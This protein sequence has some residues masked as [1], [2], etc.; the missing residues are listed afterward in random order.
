[1]K[2]KKN[3]SVKGQA[4]TNQIAEKNKTTP[5]WFYLILILIPFV[6]IISL[7]VFLRAINYGLDFEQFVAVSE[8]HPDKYYPNPDLPYKYFYNIKSAPSVLPDGFDII[9]KGNAFRVFV[10]G[11]SSAA[12]WPYVPNASFSRQLKRKLEL[13]YPENT[14]E[15]IN[16]G[17][18]AINSYTLRDFVPGILKQ[19]PDLILIYAG[20]NEYYGALGAGSSVSIG[21]S[22]FLVNTYL[23]LRDFKTV[24]LIQNTLSWIYGL[25]TG[26][27]TDEIDKQDGETLMS[28]MIGES[29]ITLNS[30]IFNAGISQ[31]E[32]NL[33]DILGW[34]KEAGIPVIIGNLTANLRDQK[35]LVSVK[36]DKLPAADEI[37]NSA[38]KTLAEG[39]IE[40]AKELFS[41]AKELDALR[42]R[43]PQKINNIIKKLAVK[44]GDSFINI[45]SVFKSH[46]PNGIVGNNLTVDHLHPNINGYWMMGNEYFKMMEKKNLLPKR[47]RVNLAEAKADSTLIANFP[48]TRLDSTIA[49]MSIIILTGQY[50]FVPK[51]TP[52]YR[53]NNY[54]EKDIVDSVSVRVINKE[55]KWESA[56]AFLSDY[57]YKKGEY[58]RCFQ[59]IEAVI[60]ERPY[61]DI[62][63]KDIIS[64][65]VDSGFLDDAKVFL[66]KL[67]KMK[68]DYFSYKWLG[69]ILLK[70]NNSKE[71]LGYLIEAVKF[72]EADS[73][74]YYNLAG[75][76][77]LNGDINSAIAA[78]EKSVSLNPHNKIAI[79]FY[80]QL[81][82]VNN[83][84]Q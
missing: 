24:Q 59:E 53:M 74:T 23:W 30:D 1:M 5:K 60:A 28:R 52:N 43:A 64:K 81:K 27:T 73:Q 26:G 34:F 68:P 31:F 15:V 3:I 41:Y 78:A 13:Y 2:N 76:Y 42:F 12:G 40:K 14:I 39:N 7:E 83:S 67:H 25:F 66:L 37:F 16:C 54:K 57:Y 20:H 29:L 33:D 55:I 79:S 10:L 47:N 82:S 19:K 4:K 50:P 48:F 45:D 44:Y 84:P 62:P 35:P 75:A 61:Y 77:Y 17:I 63:Y 38:Q 49:Q 56:H 71:A 18:S 69:Q 72:K 58:A 8:Y 22:R 80:N 32:G 65:L 51:G 6:F 46:S 9:K 21:N 70:Q 11:G 36:T